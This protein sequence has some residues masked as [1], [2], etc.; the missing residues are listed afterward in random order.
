MILLELS[1]CHVAGSYASNKKAKE[2]IYIL[3]SSFEISRL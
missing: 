2:K 3:E 1:I